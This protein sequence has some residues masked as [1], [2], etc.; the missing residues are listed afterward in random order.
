MRSYK[1]TVVVHVLAPTEQDAWYLGNA[2]AG[3]R[4][5][6][7]SGGCQDDDSRDSSTEVQEND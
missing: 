4:A 1:V 3:I 6:R 7:L 5:D 2:L